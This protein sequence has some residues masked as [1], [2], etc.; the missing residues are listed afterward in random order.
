[1]C[2]TQYSGIWMIQNVNYDRGGHL[3]NETTVEITV[4]LLQN[5]LQ[6]TKKNQP[7]VD[8]NSKREASRNKAREI[9]QKLTE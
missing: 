8:Q 3:I 7:K 1:M 4:I 6:S 5:N 9:K 2:S